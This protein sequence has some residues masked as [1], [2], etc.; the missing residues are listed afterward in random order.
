MSPKADQPLRIAQIAPV[1]APIWPGEGDS[2][3]QLVSLLTD[4]LVRRGH[5]VTLYATGDSR[6]AAS[7]RSVHPRGY[8]TD[9]AGWDWQFSEGVHA[10]HAFEHAGDHDIMHAHDYHFSLPF[11]RLVETPLVQTPH[12]EIGPEV[13]E[14]HRQRPDLHV[15]AVSEFQRRQLREVSNVSVIPHGI[16]IQAFPFDPNGGGYL[17]FLG[18]MLADKGPA[19]AIAIARAARM[20][21]VLAGPLEEGYDIAAEEAVDGERI[22]YVGRVGPDERNRLLG[23]AA[24][25]L[26]PVIYPEPFGLVLIEAMACG[27]PVVAAALG[28]VSEIVQEGVTGR[29]APSWEGL[30]ELVPAAA[31]L[32]RAGVRRAV[33]HR[34]D[35]RRMVDD[36][37][38]LYRRVVGAGGPG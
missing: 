15:V 7:L 28:A 22:R 27:T 12:I 19:Q 36:H 18:R 37:E 4:E 24:A 5:D 20:P 16:D 32:D 33:E 26:F 8:D 29:T 1:A 21:L 3:E 25:L 9:G 13:L 6:T 23:G 10:A 31:S 11:S 38:A 2:I 17:L 35:F 34:F 14:A 30:A